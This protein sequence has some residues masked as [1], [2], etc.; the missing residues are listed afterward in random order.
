MPVEIPQEALDLLI[1]PATEAPAEESP[2]NSE[3]PVEPEKEAAPLEATKE[4]APVEAKEPEAKE[5]KEKENEEDASAWNKR[6]SALAKKERDIL[7]TQKEVGELRKQVESQKAQFDE[8]I[9]Y[10]EVFTQAVG[11]FKSD[12][13]AFIKDLCQY[14]GM[15]ENTFYT[16]YTQ[17][18]LNDGQKS[19][20]LMF[21]SLKEEISSLKQELLNKEKNNLESLQSEKLSQFKNTI[22]DHVF[23]NAEQYPMIKQYNA[24]DEVFQFIEQDFKA[25]GSDPSKALTIEQACR[26]FERALNYYQQV[27]ESRTETK[28]NT[29][30]PK[31]AMS[32]T[33]STKSAP[34]ASSTPV[35]ESFE[36]RKMRIAR[37]TGLL[38]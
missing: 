37:E 10:K 33:L 23:H 13:R 9:K 24:V 4:E 29:H 5:V 8:A 28:S 7:K 32:S 6:F 2:G 17:Q 19:P 12:P 26:E 15:N 31:K 14:T 18:V 34:E 21:N 11:M 3:P 30:K 27:D 38:A 16:N 20:D 35:D 22:K 1:P 36:Q 25:K